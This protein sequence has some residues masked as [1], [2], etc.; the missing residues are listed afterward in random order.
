MKH[1]KKKTTRRRF[2]GP[3]PT[4]IEQLLAWPATIAGRFA[5]LFGP[6]PPA[7][8]VYLRGLVDYPTAAQAQAQLEELAAL[9]QDE[10]CARFGISPEQLV[11]LQQG[12]D[13]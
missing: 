9:S 10:I 4:G 13:A 7:G 6:V 11:E 3:R 2:A 1:A 12:L 8:T 5:V